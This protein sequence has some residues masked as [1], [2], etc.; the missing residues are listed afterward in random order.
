MANKTIGSVGILWRGDRHAA[1]PVVPPRLRPVFDALTALDIRPEA[2]VY[3]DDA[4]PAVRDQ[5]VHLDGVLVWVDPIMGAAD[6]TRLDALLREVSS[7]GTWVSAHPGV[8]GKMG[9]K[10]VVYRTRELSWGADTELYDSFDDFRAR[11]PASV[12]NG[13]R[14]LKPNRGN[15]GIGVWKVERASA[16]SGG[17]SSDTIVRVQSAE[18]RE[19]RTEDLTLGEFIERCRLYFDAS[20]VV[21]DQAFQPR[22]TDGMIRCYMVQTAV[23]GF[24]LQSPAPAAE[25]AFGLP[26][27]KTMFTESEPRF[28]NLR[29]QME[30]EWLPGMQRLLDIAYADLPLLWDAD[31]LYGPKTAAGDD[32]YVLCEINASCITPFPDAVPA[33]LAKAVRARLLG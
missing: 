8:I 30:S 26:A 4:T 25:R 19:S 1:D 28:Q 27:A 31:F 10:E 15:G 9:T 32:T 5:L 12:A 3:S 29:R 17:A 11:L 2:V 7:K 21:V 23:A 14:V 22:I 6:R 33:R 16:G 18:H 24:A 20:G 13:A